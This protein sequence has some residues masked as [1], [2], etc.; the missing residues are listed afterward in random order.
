[1]AITYRKLFE[2]IE[3]KGLKKVF[4]RK[5]GMNPKTINSLTKDKSVTIETINTVCKL[6]DCQPGDIMEYIPDDK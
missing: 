6:L 4:L 2:L 5:C 3:K 1:M